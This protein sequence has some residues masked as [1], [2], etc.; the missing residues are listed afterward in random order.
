[1]TVP[2]IDVAAAL[3]AHQSKSARF[4]DVR[5]PSDH[6][7]DRIPGSELLTDANFHDLIGSLDKS[8]TLIIYCYRGNSSQ[9][10]TE[11]LLQ[12]G[13]QSVHSLAGGMEAWR[14]AGHPTEAAQPAPAAS[15]ASAGGITVLAGAREKLAEYLGNEPP[16]TAVRVTLEPSGRF[17]LA[18]D[19]PGPGDQRLDVEGLPVIFEGSLAPAIQGLS[20]DWVRNGMSYG[21]SLQG[22]APP[23]PPGR[24]ELL[25]DVK[26]RIAQNKIMIF[27]KGTAERP[28]CGFSARAV[29]VLRG[30]GKPFGHKNVLEA[31]DYRFVL[32]EHSNWPTIP[33]IF[34]D[35]EFV[36]GCDIL[37][38]LHASGELAKKVAAH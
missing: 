38:E 12:H 13:F 27:M 19:E 7:A 4:F 16:S 3:T 21:F 15:A 24:A 37:M 28:M 23:A 9:G 31:P 25:E 30:L 18:L 36:G 1:M 17:G 32:S 29:E 33:Q 22:G 10:A 6:S 35:G 5:R 20:I 34:I 14:A 11:H 8:A 2:Q 26:Q